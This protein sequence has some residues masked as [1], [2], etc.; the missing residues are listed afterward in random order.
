[1]VLVICCEDDGRHHPD[2]GK[3]VVLSVI[4][5]L[6][7]P[8]CRP[9]S[10]TPEKENTCCPRSRYLLSKA[11]EENKQPMDEDLARF[12]SWLSIQNNVYSA[13]RK[14]TTVPGYSS[15]TSAWD[16]RETEW[17]ST[18][19]EFP[20][21]EVVGDW[22]FGWLL[23]V[24]G[25]PREEVYPVMMAF[26]ENSVEALKQLLNATDILSSEQEK[27]LMDAYQPVL[28]MASDMPWIDTYINGYVPSLL[29]QT[30]RC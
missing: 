13:V 15:L 23:E 18:Q 28:S 12:C 11:C 2:C 3:H 9:T 10:T 25:T 6:T 14:Y 8:F 20:G 30:R 26:Y 19:T 17:I 5:R 7:I 16:A 29:P 24:P 4:G 21:A 22:T 1:M 27:E